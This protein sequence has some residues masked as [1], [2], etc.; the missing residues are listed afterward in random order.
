MNKY[1]AFLFLSFI[2]LTACKQKPEDVV[3][4]VNKTTAKIN[5]K[6]PD[7]KQKQVDDITSPAKGNITG[8]YR[9][10][11]VKKVYTEHFSDTDRIFASYYFDDG[12]LIYVQEQNYKY[13]CSD[14][15]TPEIASAHHDSVWYDDKNTRLDINRYYF[16]KNKLIKWEP[17]VINGKPAY[18][19]DI[20]TKESLIWAQTLVLLK[21]LKDE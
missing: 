11:E 9:D 20:L 2:C 4:S 8:Y 5:K 6:L 10:D 14:K 13:N 18:T 17:P 7:Y 21:E 16:D 15:I 19:S 1:I 12:M 3:A